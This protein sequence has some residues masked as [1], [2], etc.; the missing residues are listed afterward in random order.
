MQATWAALHFS[1][2]RALGSGIGGLLMDNFGSKIAYQIYS[3]FCLIA[4]LIYSIIYLF[5]LKKVEI[6]RQNSLE[7]ED[8]QQKLPKHELSVQNEDNL[9]KEGSENPAFIKNE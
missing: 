1:V 8:K 2:G 9:R 6:N 3:G 5:W 7:N 4:A